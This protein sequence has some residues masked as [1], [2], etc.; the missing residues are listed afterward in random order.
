MRNIMCLSVIALLAGC[1]GAPREELDS[2]KS[3]LATVTRERDD[4]QAQV[5]RLQQLLDDA[6]ADL[7]KEKAVAAGVGDMV[8]KSPMDAKS[9]DAKTDGKRSTTKSKHAHKS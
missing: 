7:A 6:K 9:I 2:T 1:D 3:T 4:L 8:A 5:A